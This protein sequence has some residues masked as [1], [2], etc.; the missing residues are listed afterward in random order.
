[1]SVDWEVSPSNRKRESQF[2][3]HRTLL[4]AFWDVL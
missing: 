2:L 1:M 3:N 4:F